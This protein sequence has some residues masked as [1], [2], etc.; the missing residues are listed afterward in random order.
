[1]SVLSRSMPILISRPDLPRSPPSG[2]ARLLRAAARGSSRIA[3]GST[4][5]GTAG[6][7]GS[8]SQRLGNQAFARLPARR[9]ASRAGLHDEPLPGRQLGDGKPP[10]GE[11]GLMG[12]GLLREDGEAEI[13]ED[14]EAAPGDAIPQVFEGGDLVH[15]RVEIDKQPGDALGA[16]AVQ[17]IGNLAAD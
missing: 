5:A 14:D 11:E 6:Q 12:T 9:A 8:T 16:G 4:P 17:R 10:G 3:A 13:V 2:P 7:A 15:R 1:M